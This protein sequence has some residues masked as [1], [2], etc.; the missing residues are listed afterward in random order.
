MSLSFNSVLNFGYQSSSK[1]SETMDVTNFTITTNKTLECPYW[2]F[3]SDGSSQWKGGASAGANE[4]PAQGRVILSKVLTSPDMPLDT[5]TLFWGAGAHHRHSGT[6]R[7]TQGSLAMQIDW[8][9]AKATFPSTD[10]IPNPN[11][12]NIQDLTGDLPIV[13]P[14]K[15][16]IRELIKLKSN[17]TEYSGSSLDNSIKTGTGFYQGKIYS[18]SSKEFSTKDTNQ[19]SFSNGRTSIDIFLVKVNDGTDDICYLRIAFTYDSIVFDSVKANELTEMFN[20]FGIYPGNYTDNPIFT[21]ASSNNESKLDNTLWTEVSINDQNKA[22]T[23]HLSLIEFLPNSEQQE[24]ATVT[25]ES[26][27]GWSIGASAGGSSNGSGGDNGG[28]VPDD[29][30]VLLA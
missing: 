28:V 12:Q 16:I 25:T 8:N 19:S 22:E 7:S 4:L 9:N 24:H 6:Y 21:V 14:E 11:A 2:I 30:E 15:A 20:G 3:L 10:Q 26:G 27:S 13:N 1:S 29:G 18:F 23:L 5:F 17:S